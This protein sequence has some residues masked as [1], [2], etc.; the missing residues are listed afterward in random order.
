MKGEKG[1]ISFRE[2]IILEN[3][4]PGQSKLRIE[5]Y[6]VDTATADDFLGICEI[7]VPEY[8]SKSIGEKDYKFFTE[9]GSKQIAILA[10]DQIHFIKQKLRMY[11]GPCKPCC[12]CLNTGITDKDIERQGLVSGDY[13]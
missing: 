7:D 8:Y 10:L 5:L 9:D 11:R 4:R 2:P 1:S 6:D 3:A 13:K 12:C